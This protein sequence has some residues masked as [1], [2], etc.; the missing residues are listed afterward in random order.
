MTSLFKNVPLS[1]KLALMFALFFFNAYLFSQV[2]NLFL[3]ICYG[4]DIERAS[5]VSMGKFVSEN[6]KYAFLVAQTIGHFGAFALTALLIA[7]LETGFVSRRLSLSV[8]PAPRLIAIGFVG[9][10]AA[11]PVIQFLIELNQKI[12]LPNALKPIAELAKHEG[13]II[14]VLLGGKSIWLFLANALGLAVEPAFVEE[15]F[16]RGLLLGALLKSKI[17][18]ILSI[19]VTGFLFSLA[20]LEFE[21]LLAIWALGAFLGYLY[22]VSGSLW[23]SIIAHFTN[24]F[25][26][27]LLKYLYDSGV[28]KT[29]ITEADIPVYAVAVSTVLFLLCLFVLHKWRRPVD[30]TLELSEPELIDSEE[31]YV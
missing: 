10:L 6:D 31:H 7:Q 4:M 12:P 2:G 26:L 18:P 5:A 3:T 8:K 20:H 13:K 29:D 17:N 23:L 22:Y 9:I 15:L 25:L 16:F 28:I 14:D 24:N 27:I 11:Q 1:A 19:I 30:F 21:N